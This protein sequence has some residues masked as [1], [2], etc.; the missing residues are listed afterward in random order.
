MSDPVPREQMII[1]PERASEIKEEIYEQC[2]RAMRNTGLCE[3]ASIAASQKA[4]S[5][6]MFNIFKCVDESQD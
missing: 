5:M 2:Y 6:I 3:K 1:P 4:V